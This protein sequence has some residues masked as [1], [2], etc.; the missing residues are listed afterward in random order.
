MLGYLFFRLLVWVI[1]LLSWTQLYRLS[2][3]IAWLLGDVL[4]YRR[5]VINK[6]LEYALPKLS[7]SE[8]SKLLKGIYTNLTDILLESFKSYTATL[9]E[10][11]QRYK[12]T[13][14]DN[15]NTEADAG[16]DV[17][18][19]AAHYGN[20]EWGT[21]M[22]PE[23][24]RHTVIGL[25]KPLKSKMLNDYVFGER[26]KNGAQMVSVYDKDKA[27]LKEDKLVKS[28]VFIADQNPTNKAKSIP[29]TFFGRETLALH[30][31][32][33]FA[34]QNN[35]AVHYLRIKRIAR[36]HYTVDSELL[37]DDVLS[38]E[39][40]ALTQKYFDILQSQI[41]DNPTA[42]LWTHKRWKH[43]IKY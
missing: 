10:I 35:T 31:A 2:D 22:L 23:Q 21:L 36:G 17:T 24:S 39:Y 19:F 5:K 41:L 42:W 38:L 26:A 15:L 25:V 30:G 33:D 40:G 16:R 7:K 20:W 4:K 27:M 8:N 14:A 32:E 37:C 28:V 9:D 11:R 13:I 1:G 6:N 12:V 29:V 3:G 34:R 43:Q 18:T